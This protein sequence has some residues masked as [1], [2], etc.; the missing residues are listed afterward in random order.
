MFGFAAEAA[1]LK[2]CDPQNISKMLSADTNNVSQI[3]QKKKIMDDYDDAWK[4]DGVLSGFMTCVVKS[5]DVTTI[6]R[7]KAIKY[8]HYVNQFKLG[9]TLNIEYKLSTDD[10]MSFEIF[11]LTENGKKVTDTSF[12]FIATNAYYVLRQ[13]RLKNLGTG[14]SIAKITNEGINIRYANNVFNLRNY[15]AS[16]YD[17][18]WIRPNWE[19]EFETQVVTL[20]CQ[21]SGANFDTIIKKLKSRKQQ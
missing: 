21:K 12:G 3:L 18:I 8:T 1:D 17:G 20:D 16:E 9:D 2:S 5:A 15:S 6:F 11:A 13:A 19:N 14:Q 7:G 10:C 4:S